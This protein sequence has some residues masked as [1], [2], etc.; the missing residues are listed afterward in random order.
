MAVDGRGISGLDLSTLDPQIHAVQWY[1]TDGEL[2]LV[3]APGNPGANIA[4]TDLEFVQPALDAWQAAANAIDN[5]SPPAPADMAV[6]KINSLS[7][8]CEVAIESGF[9]SDA[10]GSEHTYQSERDDQLNLIGSSSAGVDM[11]YKC[12]DANGAWAYRQHTAV[13]LKQVLADGAAVKLGYLQRFGQLRDQVTAIAAGE[14]LTDEGTAMTDDEKRTAI[15]AV[16]VN[17]SPDAPLSA[18]LCGLP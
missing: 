2:E 8:A 1:G 5:P 14:V 6:K 12:A 15:D 18:G 3:S 11:L 10:L 17:K 9:V 7:T 13:Q 16:L 4:I